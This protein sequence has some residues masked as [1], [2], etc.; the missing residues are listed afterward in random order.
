MTKKKNSGTFAGV[1]S[2]AVESKTGRSWD[3]WFDILDHIDATQMTHPQ[4]ARYLHDNYPIGG[5]WAQTITGGYE[6]ARGMRKKHQM[7]DGFQISRSKTIGV[8]V[9]DL[10]QAW[11][12]PGGRARWLGDAPL[13]IRKANTNKSLRITWNDPESH[14]DVHFY[15]KGQAKSQV[16]VQ[17]SKLANE[18]LAKE[19]KSYWAEQL[20]ALKDLLE[21]G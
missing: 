11:H 12:D 1:S 20:V 14:L 17:A 19:M 2:K 13:E 10:Y 6:Q 3:A 15:A 7:P 16:V 21:R 8:P 9:S 4:I 18:K 5:W